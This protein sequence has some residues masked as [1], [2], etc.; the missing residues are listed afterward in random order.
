MSFTKVV[1]FLDS[2]LPLELDNARTNFLDQS[3]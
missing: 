2:A 3:V 1:R